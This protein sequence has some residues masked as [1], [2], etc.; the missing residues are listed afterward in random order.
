MSNIPKQMLQCLRIPLLILVRHLLKGIA[1]SKVAF[2]VLVKPRNELT[3]QSQACT[4]VFR[5]LFSSHGLSDPNKC[6]VY[7]SL[8][9]STPSHWAYKPDAQLIHQQLRQHSKWGTHLE[10]GKAARSLHCQVSKHPQALY[11]VLKRLLLYSA[12]LPNVAYYASDA[13]PSCSQIIQVLSNIIMFCSPETRWVQDGYGWQ[14]F[15]Q[16]LHTLIIYKHIA[17][18][19]WY[20][21]LTFVPDSRVGR[22]LQMATTENCEDSEKVIVSTVTWKRTVRHSC[23]PFWAAVSFHWETRCSSLCRHARRDFHG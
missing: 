22:I 11:I 19:L 5:E 15:F 12:M 4:H 1:Y 3:Q 18:C 7:N 16:L 10:L 9:C 8:G 17:F 14:P 13:F 21:L 20:F 23:T 2:V 6:K